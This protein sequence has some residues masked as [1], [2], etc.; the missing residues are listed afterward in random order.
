[1]IK[2]SFKKIE[3]GTSQSQKC[4]FGHPELDAI[5]NNSLAK[6]HVIA[7]QEDHPTTHYLAL[8]RCFLSHHYTQGLTSIVF[9]NNKKWK[10]LI[11]PALKR[12]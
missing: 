1:M 5:L 2:S 11:S 9:D 12:T 3:K 8:S 7:I 4:F 10:Y 6:G